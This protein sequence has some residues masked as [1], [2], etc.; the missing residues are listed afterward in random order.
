MQWMWPI[1]QAA[2]QF[3]LDN[4]LDELM[5]R[6]QTW[7]IC[8]RIRQTHS[9]LLLSLTLLWDGVLLW[10]VPYF[11][12]TPLWCFENYRYLSYSPLICRFQAV[13]FS[14]IP[15]TWL[16]GNQ[17]HV[18]WLWVMLFLLDCHSHPLQIHGL[19]CVLLP[20]I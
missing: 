19:L 12:I 5:C 7:L 15:H 17:H 8:L 10:L 11:L 9:F 14:R 4:E 16:F 18:T 2:L 20:G 1:V 3:M 6:S 13:I